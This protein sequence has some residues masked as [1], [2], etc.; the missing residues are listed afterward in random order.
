MLDSNNTVDVKA[1]L[2]SHCNSG[3]LQLFD[4]VFIPLDTTESHELFA[5]PTTISSTGRKEWSQHHWFYSV[6]SQ[7]TL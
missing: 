4:T 2:L 6:T 7:K 3:A 5:N 1:V